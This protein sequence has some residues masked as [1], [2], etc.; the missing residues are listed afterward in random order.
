MKYFI[1]LA[2]KGTNYRGWQKQNDVKSIQEVLEEALRQ[3]LHLDINCVSCGR[4]DAGVHASQFFCHI[5]VPELLDFDPVFRLNKMLPD[6]IAIFNFLPVERNA[7]AQN[8]ATERTYNYFIHFHS[9]PFLNEL[10]TL[11][12]QDLDLEKMKIAVSLV[13]RYSDFKA[14]CKK[15][16]IYKHTL[17]EIFSASLSINETNTRL[18][19]QITANRFL[20]GM[21]RLLIGNILEIGMGKL[22]LEKFELCLKNGHALPFHK[23]AYPQGLYLSKV[24]YPYLDIDSKSETT[25]LLNSAFEKI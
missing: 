14:F 18:R 2:Y 20:R 22:S 3:M 9:D 25:L 13:E 16:A 17:C 15:P 5:I 7:H 4:T 6:D 1:H 23:E 8:D 21:M 19:F 24:K 12:D 10:S 11:H